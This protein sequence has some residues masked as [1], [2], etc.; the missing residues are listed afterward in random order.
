MPEAIKKILKEVKKGLKD[1]E[2]KANEFSTLQD[3]ITFLIG[4]NIVELD[5]EAL[6][7]FYGK[8]V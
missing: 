5:K 1:F 6:K 4:E 2:K 8:E 3:F 7:T